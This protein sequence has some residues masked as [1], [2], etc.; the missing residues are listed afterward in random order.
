MPVA[1]VVVVV[2]GG[3]QVRLHGRV[4]AWGTVPWHGMAWDQLTHVAVPIWA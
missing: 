2:V 1:L 3:S 4:L